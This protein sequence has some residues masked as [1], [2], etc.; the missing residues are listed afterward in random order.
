MLID[1]I[2][3]MGETP[4]SYSGRGMHDKTCVSVDLDGPAVEFAMD[5]GA[6]LQREHEG[7]GEDLDMPAV[8]TDGMGRGVVIYFPGCPWPTGRPIG[9]DAEA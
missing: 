4:R 5:L 8:R 7:D 1:A 3:N 9:D 2:E 6:A